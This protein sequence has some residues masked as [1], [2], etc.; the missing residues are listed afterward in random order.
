MAMSD[1][2]QH[3]LD[4]IASKSSGIEALY[5]GLRGGPSKTRDSIRAAVRE[6]ARNRGKNGGRALDFKFYQ[7]ETA[8]VWG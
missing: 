1:N 2:D 8:S 3:I 5:V 4:A 6:L 7:S